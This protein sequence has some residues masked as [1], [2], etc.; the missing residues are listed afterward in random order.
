M[1]TE[2]YIKVS[3]PALLGLSI[4]I[5]TLGWLLWLF[6]NQAHNITKD[7]AIHLDHAQY[8]PITG[9]WEWLGKEKLK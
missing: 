8:H 5:A 2:E 4:G 7:E 1:N 3:K 6:E 9:D